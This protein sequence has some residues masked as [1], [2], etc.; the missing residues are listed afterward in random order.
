MTHLLARTSQLN[1]FSTVKEEQGKAENHPGIEGFLFFMLRP[2][3]SHPFAD[4][5]T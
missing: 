5:P 2:L 1:G 3:L 4:E